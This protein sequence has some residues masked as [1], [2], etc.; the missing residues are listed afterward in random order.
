MFNEKYM[1]LLIPVKIIKY[2]QTEELDWA[3]PAYFCGVCY[4]WSSDLDIEHADARVVPHSRA[5]RLID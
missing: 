2:A 4:F 1:Q 5:P 3:I